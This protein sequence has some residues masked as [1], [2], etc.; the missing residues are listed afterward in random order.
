MYQID[1]T[2]RSASS[3]FQVSEE[4]LARARK[5]MEEA[6]V[7]PVEEKPVI[8]PWYR[9]PAF[10]RSAALVAACLCVAVIAF[11]VP[12]LTGSNKKAMDSEAVRQ[13][14]MVMTTAAEIQAGAAGAAQGNAA[15]EYDKEETVVET[16]ASGFTEEKSATMFYR[17]ISAKQQDALDR[18]LA[19][20]YLHAY[21]GS[22][23]RELQPDSRLLTAKDLIDVQ[24][25]AGEN[26]NLIRLTFCVNDDVRQAMPDGP[27]TL[28]F[29]VLAEREN[30]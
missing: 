20:E 8:L 2:Y 22:L 15:V 19:G 17:T 11:G 28:V 13:E 9:R 23:T 14:D 29:D 7:R 21:D 18:V 30:P 12:R 10:A 3:K 24:E 4:A 27:E 5:A 26:G 16:T 25:I 1:E 6:A